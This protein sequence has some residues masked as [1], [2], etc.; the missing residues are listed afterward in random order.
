MKKIESVR[1]LIKLYKNKKYSPVEEVN[2]IYQNIEEKEKF[3]N[4]FTEI[5]PKQDVLKEAKEAENRYLKGNERS[6]EGIV[7]SI[8]DILGIKN[9]ITKYGSKTKE[10]SNPE[11]EDCPIVE[12]IKINGGIIVGKTTSPEFVL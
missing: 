3:I 4:G 8:K 11:L 1:N 2:K 6:L 5:F 12:S 9:K 7:F 10:N